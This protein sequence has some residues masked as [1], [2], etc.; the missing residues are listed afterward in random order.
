MK[1]IS[2]IKDFVNY[3]FEQQNI[4]DCP[5]NL[6]LICGDL[7]VD[8]FADKDNEKDGKKTPQLHE[9]KNTMLS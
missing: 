7:N 2:F 5:N 6:L 4:K 8:A 3:T 9:L 1:Q